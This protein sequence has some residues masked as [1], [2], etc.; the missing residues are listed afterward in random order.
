MLAHKLSIADSA[1]PPAPQ[2]L[3]AHALTSVA[4]AI[5]LTDARGTIIWA[6]DAFVRLSGF[7]LEEV[8]QRTP[9]ILRS[10]KQSAD[11]YTQLWQTIQAGQ[12]WQGD[13]VDR[14]KDGSLCTVD[15]IITPLFDEQGNI[16]HFIAIQHD[17]TGRQ[18]DSEHAHHLAN[19]DVL[20]TLPNRACFFRLLETAIRN[21]RRNGRMLAT[22]F[23]DL[24]RF[25]PVNDSC[26]HHIGDQ[27]LVAVAER[28]RV[29]LRQADTVARIGGDEFVILIDD[30]DDAHIATR[31]AQKLVLTL[32]QPFVLHGHSIHMSASV[33][34][35]IYPAD[36]DDS[37]TLLMHADQAMYRAKSCGGN[38][39]RLYNQAE[40]S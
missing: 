38:Q 7:S 13:V 15:E 33:G 25:K 22:L 19:H 37:H 6:N 8:I 1:P 31:L 34:V 9:A 32:A 12:V 20:T 36:G 5:F 18:R 24:D 4:N 14:R 27:L 3:L 10:G 21:A 2:A 17:I 11:F 30:L 39:A 29:A 26:G 23:L 35:A 16:T 28:I 40:H